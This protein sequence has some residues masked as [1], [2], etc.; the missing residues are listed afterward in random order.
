MVNIIPQQVT[1]TKSLYAIKNAL[2]LITLSN[3]YQKRTTS[4]NF[5]KKLIYG[6]A[7][8]W[9]RR[10]H[11]PEKLSRQLRQRDKRQSLTWI[12]C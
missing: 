4:D 10:C 7:F 12:L 6:Y 3:F 2:I 11:L 1:H 9:F 5:I 8:Y